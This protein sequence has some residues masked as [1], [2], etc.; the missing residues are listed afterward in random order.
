VFA[1]FIGLWLWG[2]HTGWKVP[3]FSGLVS[4]AREAKDDWCAVHGVPESQCVECNPG[5]FPRL[6]SFGWCKVHGVHECPLEHPELAQMSISPRIAAADLARAT[7]ALN[8]AERPENNR[9]CKLHERRIQFVSQDAVEKAGIDVAP[10]WTASVV[11]SVTGNGEITYDPTRTA[12]L[13]VRVP[14]SVFKVYEQVGDPVKQG[15][16]LALVDAAEVGKAKSEFLHALLQVRLVSETLERLEE[17]RRQGVIPDRTYREQAAS[18]HEARVRLVTAR[19]ALTNLGLPVAFEDFQGVPAEK[20]PDRI[21]FLGLPESV[22]RSL[23]PQKTTGNLL[24]VTAPFDGIVTTRQVVEGEVVDSSKLLL[25]VVDVRQM[26]LTL[27]FRAEDAK[28]VSLSNEVRFR[29]DSGVEARGKI[30]WISTEADAKT[31]TLKVRAALDNSNGRLQA[32]TFGSGRVILREESQ[33]IVVPNVAVHWEG[34][35]HVVF[36]RDKHFLE[37]RAPKVFHVRT[38]RVGARD[39]E[40]TEIIAGLLP[41]EIVAAKGS[42]VLRSELLKNDLGEG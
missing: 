31:R 12:R 17:A 20:L 32:N 27:D 13:S 1:A 2:H 4:G 39:G 33:V 24:A 19:E 8:F 10:V 14:G 29:T 26:W 34:C 16:V 6:K 41:G 3:R 21:R 22:A 38:V 40:Q 7:R 37:A 36:V 25:M 23:D 11:E 18:V 9:K 28:R 35:C 5:L 30:H 15:E 42:G